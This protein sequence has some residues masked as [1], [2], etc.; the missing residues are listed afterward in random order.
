VELAIL[1][2]GA[3]TW[4]EWESTESVQSGSVRTDKEERHLWWILTELDKEDAKAEKKEKMRKG[5]KVMVARKKM[6]AD[7]CQPSIMERLAKSR[8]Q[9]K[10]APSHRPPPMDTLKTYNLLGVGS[11]PVVSSPPNITPPDKL[12]QSARI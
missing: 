12:R 9:P 11:R 5:M 1:T 4:G 8:M 3:A 6:G 2:E 10:D 7:K